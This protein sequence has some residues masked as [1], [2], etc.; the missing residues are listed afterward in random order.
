MLSKSV[1]RMETLDVR[2][3]A[4]IVLFLLLSFPHMPIVVEI[5][6]NTDLIKNLKVLYMLR[7]PLTGSIQYALLRMHTS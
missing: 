1:D 5:M 2:V 7:K 4:C 6:T 3:C